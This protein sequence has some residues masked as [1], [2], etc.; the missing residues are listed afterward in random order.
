MAHPQD[1][2]AHDARGAG[3]QQ[4]AQDQGGAP[5]T[6]AKMATR[7]TSNTS[8]GNERSRRRPS[9]DEQVK[10][11]AE[12]ATG[13]PDRNRDNRAQQNGAEANGHDMRAPQMMRLSRSRPLASVPKGCASVGLWSRPRS[14]RRRMDRAPATARR[15]PGPASAR[16]SP[17][18]KAPRGLRR[19]NSATAVSQVG[20]PCA[21]DLDSGLARGDWAKGCRPNAH[22]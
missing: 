10:E 18:P 8:A 13:H 22:E 3:R 2:A 1:G 4:H 21:P 12:V 20:P 17:R 5:Q 15:S 11:P 16:R 19:A 9:A 14:R 7:L 6:W